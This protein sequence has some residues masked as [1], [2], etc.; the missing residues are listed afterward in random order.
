MKD[1]KLKKLKE[2]SVKIED[3]RLNQVIRAK[4]LENIAQGFEELIK[5]EEEHEKILNKLDV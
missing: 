4:I 1:M 5:V 2:E 3:L